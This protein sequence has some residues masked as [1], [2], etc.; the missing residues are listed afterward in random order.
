MPPLDTHGAEESGERGGGSDANCDCWVEPTSSYHTI[1]NGS[2]WDASGFNSSDEGSYGPIALPFPFYL[3]GQTWDSV[4]INVNG[5]VSFYRI[6]YRVIIPHAL[7][8]IFTIISIE[9]CRIITFSVTY[10]FSIPSVKNLI[11][12]PFA[13]P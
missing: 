11:V 9:N 1:L 7:S 12:I 3:Y 4:Y 10:I 13:L 6:N 2:E 8:K 5:N